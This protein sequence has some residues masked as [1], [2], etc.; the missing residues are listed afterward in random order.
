MNTGC[1]TLRV[2]VVAGNQPA[3][4]M[5]S[6]K[7]RRGGFVT[8]LA[9]ATLA[10]VVA[11]AADL[12]VA[13]GADFQRTRLSANAAQLRQLLLAGCQAA[14][15]RIADGNVA[16]PVFT[17]ALPGE[18]ASDGA[19]LTVTPSDGNSADDATM[20]ID[21]RWGGHRASERIRFHRGDSGWVLA[22]VTLDS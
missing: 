9:I 17:I 1:R 16:G 12:S 2:F 22:E 11:A 14:R 18:L 6:A 4:R 20:S 15:Q 13:V 8:L 21:A 7:G 10:I 5:A 3:R 19:V